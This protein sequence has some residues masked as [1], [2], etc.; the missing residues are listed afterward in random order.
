ML[1]TRIHW[2]AEVEF[3]TSIVSIGVGTTHP[4]LGLK[5]GI[6]PINMNVIPA[7][8]TQ[9][10]SPDLEVDFDDIA[11]SA[12]AIVEPSNFLVVPTGLDQAMISWEPDNTGWILQ[13]SDGLSSAN[14]TDSPSGSTN[15]VIV[16]VTDQR[17]LS[18]LIQP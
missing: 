7:G 6:R 8:F 12:T 5:L 9:G 13:Q 2:I 15:L 11:R 1:K 14:W 4:Q 10:T 16:P 18:R 3:A 17:G